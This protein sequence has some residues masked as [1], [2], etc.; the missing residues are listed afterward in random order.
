ME[1][2]RTIDDR[3]I[4][5]SKLKILPGQN[6]RVHVEAKADRPDIDY[7]VLDEKLN[8]LT[9]MLA[10]K[11]DEL[12]IDE[13]VR[14]LKAGENPAEDGKVTV[15]EEVPKVLKE[16]SSLLGWLVALLVLLLSFLFSVIYMGSI[17]FME[18]A[19]SRGPGRGGRACRKVSKVCH[20]LRSRIRDKICGK[21]RDVKT[22][23]PRV[24]EQSFRKYL[25]N[26]LFSKTLWREKPS[27]TDSQKAIVAEQNAFVE[28]VK[29]I[30]EGE[31]VELVVAARRRLH[32]LLNKYRVEAYYLPLLDSKCNVLIVRELELNQK[33]VNDSAAIAEAIDQ[34]PFDPVSAGL[35]DLKEASMAEVV[36]FDLS[37][38]KDGNTDAA[39]RAYVNL[40]RNLQVLF[41]TVGTT[42]FLPIYSNYS[43]EHYKCLQE[44]RVE[45]RRL[46]AQTE[47]RVR[48]EEEKA[49]RTDW[50]YVSMLAS[51]G[52]STVAAVGGGVFGVYRFFSKRKAKLLRREI[53]AAE[54]NLMISHMERARR[55]GD[56]GDGGSGGG[57][58]ESP[59][60]PARADVIRF[61]D[62]AVENVMTDVTG[63]EAESTT[64]ASA[65]FGAGSSSERPSEVFEE[66]PTTAFE[67]LEVTVRKLTEEGVSKEEHE[68]DP[69]S[70][71][72]E[73]KGAA[74]DVKSDLL[75]T[76]MTP[77]NLETFYRAGYY[78]TLSMLMK[79]DADALLQDDELHDDP[80]YYSDPE[81][82]ISEEA[83]KLRE[84]QLW[85]RFTGSPRTAEAVSE[86]VV[87]EEVGAVMSDLEESVAQYVQRDVLDPSG[88]NVTESGFKR[89]HAMGTA[90][91]GT[92]AASSVVSTLTYRK[93]HSLSKFAG[94]Q[95]SPSSSGSPSR[96][97]IVKKQ[98]IPK[99]AR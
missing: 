8:N 66:T 96:T 2:I 25:S 71:V 22:V 80:A 60:Q 13:E 20:G 43:G 21:L 11:V 76:F 46:R 56:S 93:P 7:R 9:E 17:R 70:V 14:L 59:Q 35:L 69:D 1:Q 86:L 81:I 90:I 58:L 78:E 77:N 6:R 10:A 40:I 47:K 48:D 62:E 55:G 61:A 67:R 42:A 54:T 64:S 98:K 79:D 34:P 4:A 3:L 82:D 24:N 73:I 88:S 30:D 57:V 41:E 65:L 95:V 75:K 18:F 16:S 27:M 12:V 50:L 36:D 19:V 68:K 45:D 92:V 23:S 32:G 28:A 15:V 74:A 83:K 39:F 31:E 72:E 91:A 84:G 51:F 29:I 44:A 49:K 33:V 97:T 52:V 63:V 38:V 85:R 5:A 53:E 94:K 26:Y 99:F 87:D 89:G 37:S